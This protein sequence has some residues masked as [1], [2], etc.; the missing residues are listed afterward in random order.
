MARELR[1]SGAE[2]RKGKMRFS[3]SIVAL[4]VAGN[5]FG[6][7]AEPAAQV[8]GSSAGKSAEA[9]RAVGQRRAQWSADP[10][11]GWIRT[12]QGASG[13]KPKNESKRDSE[14]NRRGN[15]RNNIRH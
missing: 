4:I 10:E 14:K 5:L 7:S 6:L 2:G 8:N 13:T 11:R 15:E 1:L 12:N 3:G 9:G